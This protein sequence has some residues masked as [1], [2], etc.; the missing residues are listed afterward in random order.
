MPMCRGVLACIG[1]YWLALAMRLE[2]VGP[3]SGFF[4]TSNRAN[5]VQRW[6]FHKAIDFGPTLGP[7]CVGNRWSISL[8]LLVANMAYII[9]SRL[10]I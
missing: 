2:M 8:V 1:Q 10:A 6:R 9:G 3:R 5:A 4:D 7:L